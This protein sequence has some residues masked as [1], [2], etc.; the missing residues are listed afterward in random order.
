MYRKRTPD[1]EDG[2]PKAFKINFRTDEYMTED[3]RLNLNHWLD[4]VKE[5]YEGY[6]NGNEFIGV[7]DVQLNIERTKPSLGSYTEPPPGLRSKIKAILNIRNDK[8]NCLRLC[9]TAAI[10]PVTK[11][12]TRENKYINNLVDHWEDNENT[13]D[14]LTR[15][16]N[17]YNINIWVHQPSTEDD[18]KAEVSQKWSTFIKGRKNVRISAWDEH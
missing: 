12:A 3:H 17:K 9:I 1:G 16:Q 2:V 11:V 14:Y 4:H 7:S 8:F 10:Y 15:M 5:T 13:Y 18:T 6:G